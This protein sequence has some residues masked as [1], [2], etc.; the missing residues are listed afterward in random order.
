MM[1]WR[2]TFVS[3]E[4]V[5]MVSQLC[6]EWLMRKWWPQRTFDFWG[7][8]ARYNSLCNWSQLNDSSSSYLFITSGGAFSTDCFPMCIRNS[9]IYTNKV[10]CEHRVTQ[11]SLYLLLSFLAQFLFFF[12]GWVFLIKHWPYGFSLWWPWGWCRSFEV[13]YLS[14]GH[15]GIF[16]QCW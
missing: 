8:I 3:R 12:S 1:K 16:H 4:R 15:H 10:T 6:D 2:W 5:Q 14:T 7:L 9:N 13:A 11:K